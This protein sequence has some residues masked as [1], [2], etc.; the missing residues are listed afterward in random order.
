MPYFADQFATNCCDTHPTAMYKTIV[1]IDDSP[2]ERFL[3]ETLAKSS[4]FAQVVIPFAT[5]AEA[6][7]YLADPAATMPDI[8]LV[9]I[10]MPLINGFQ[11]L[12]EY[13]KLPEEATGSCKVIM[14][15]S[16]LA[17]EDKARVKSYP[18]VKAFIEKP[19]SEKKFRELILV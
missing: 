17:P 11:F 13:G 9:D 8:I 3:A 15:S 19:L 4:G 16:T 18:V 10:Q 7:A 12:E 2:L 1:I 6:L 14:F 5:A